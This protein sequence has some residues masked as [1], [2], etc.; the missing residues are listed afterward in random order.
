MIEQPGPSDPSDKGLPTATDDG[1]TW[2][3][4][5]ALELHQL[6]SDR[7]TRESGQEE[8]A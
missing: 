3:V 1:E 4:A 6:I 7:R 5:Q 8:R 2:L